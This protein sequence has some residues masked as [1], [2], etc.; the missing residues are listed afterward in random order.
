MSLNNLSVAK[1]FIFMALVGMI[2]LIFSASLWYIE[3]EKQLSA[4]EN[5][6]QGLAF[7]SALFRILEA[8]IDHRHLA[9]LVRQAQE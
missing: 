3:I 9:L 4:V 7:H 5:E 8:M 6:I 2:P 1:K